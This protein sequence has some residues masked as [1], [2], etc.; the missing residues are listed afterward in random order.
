MKKMFSWRRFEKYFKKE[1]LSKRYY[2]ENKKY[3]YELKLGQLTID[4]Y[5]KTFLDLTRFVPYIKDG[6][7]KIQW[8]ISGLPQ[9]FQDRIE[10][11]EPKTLEYTIRKERYCYEQFK[12]K[13]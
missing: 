13:A 2:D 5:V 10:F 7:T 8:F 4:E 12:Q 1:C 11:D 9:Y 6:K 3:F